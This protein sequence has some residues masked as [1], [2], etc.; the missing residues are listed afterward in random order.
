LDNKPRH[1][2]VR[3]KA[4]KTLARGRAGEILYGLVDF[5]LLQR[6]PERDRVMRATKR[7]D[8]LIRQV[9]RFEPRVDL[10]AGALRP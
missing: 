8:Y 7:H 1:I 10:S 2:I 6:T 3:P 5:E 9:H 4:D